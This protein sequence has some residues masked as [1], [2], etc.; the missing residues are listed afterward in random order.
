MDEK[1]YSFNCMLFDNVRIF[2]KNN[3]F[4]RRLMQKLTKPPS[5][6]DNILTEE[7]YEKSRVYALDRNTF[8]NVQELYG[9]I[10]NTVSIQDFN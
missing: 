10:F 3:F 7:V 5:V 1:D 4:Q 6:L 8:G 2:V 9:N